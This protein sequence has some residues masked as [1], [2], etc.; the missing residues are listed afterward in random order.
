MMLSVLQFYKDVCRKG[1][2][3]DPTSTCF[4]TASCLHSVP[5][6]FAHAYIVG[7]PLSFFFILIYSQ[8]VSSSIYVDAY[9]LSTMASFIWFNLTRLLD[10]DP[11]NDSSE[12]LIHSFV[13]SCKLALKNTN[14]LPSNLLSS[15]IR[16][17][18][19]L[20]N[21]SSGSL[22]FFQSALK[23]FTMVSTQK[24]ELYV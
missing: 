9:E 15:L 12:C 22:T 17:W 24:D 21:D 16:S 4:M 1:S 20:V 5:Y 10:L 18:G 2:N 14:F 6:S 8:A 3:D 11:W 19:W 7:L 23:C 13:L